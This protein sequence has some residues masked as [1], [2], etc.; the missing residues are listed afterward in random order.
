[1]IRGG[2]RHTSG[3]GCDLRLGFDRQ[4]S[5]PEVLRGPIQYRRSVHSAAALV[6]CAGTAGALGVSGGQFGFFTKR[7]GRR[8]RRWS[9]ITKRIEA[10][11]AVALGELV[12]G[13]GHEGVHVGQTGAGCGGWLRRWFWSAS[14]SWIVRPDCSL[15]SSAV[16][17][18][19]MRW[20]CAL[21]RSTDFW[22]FSVRSSIMGSKSRSSMRP[23]LL[24]SGN[25]GTR[26]LP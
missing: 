21:A 20:D 5:L 17:R 18:R 1:M 11:F 4:K 9:W 16:E 24:L 14:C 25:G 2:G 10:G 12:V 13:E 22:G 3:A 15:R 26:W 23:R 19:R 6:F 7:T 8:G